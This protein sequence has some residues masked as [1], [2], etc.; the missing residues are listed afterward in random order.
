LFGAAKS[1]A[2]FLLDGATEVKKNFIVLP[3]DPNDDED[4]DIDLEGLEAGYAARDLR[5]T[6]LALNLTQEDFADRFKVSLGTLRDWEQARVKMP[7]F[8]RAYLQVIAAEPKLV[9]RIVA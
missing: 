1:A 4:R 8:A 5:R 2:V 7:S 9:E 6:R 3:A